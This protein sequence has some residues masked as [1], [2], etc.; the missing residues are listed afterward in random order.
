MTLDCVL[1]CG[2]TWPYDRKTVEKTR[3]KIFKY[4]ERYTKHID[5]RIGGEEEKKGVS[6]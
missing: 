3:K 4:G 1:E 6:N 5:G 2:Q